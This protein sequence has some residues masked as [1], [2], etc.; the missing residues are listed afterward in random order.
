LAAKALISVL[1]EPR[2]R[3]GGTQRGIL[4]KIVTLFGK[5]LVFLLE[6]EGQL[7]MMLRRPHPLAG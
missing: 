4:L 5:K 7:A 1:F 3:H 2:F 6:V